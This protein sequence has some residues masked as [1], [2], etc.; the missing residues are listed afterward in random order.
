MDRYLMK[1]SAPFVQFS[2]V[3][4]TDDF[5]HLFDIEKTTKQSND[6]YCQLLLYRSFTITHSQ[7]PDFIAH[8]CNLVNDPNK[9]LNKFEKLL[10]LNEELFSGTRNQSRLVKF[11]TC[12]ETKR[13]KLADE[14]A[15]ADKSKPVKKY[16]NAESEDRHFSFKET[17]LAIENLPDNKEKIYF[18]TSEIYEYRTADIVMKNQ[19]LPDFDIE[20]EKLIGKIQTLAKLR[21]EIEETKHSS[22]T[23]T[24][25]NE[26]IMLNGPINILT[27]AFKQMMTSVKPNGKPYI[28]GKIKDI[29]VFL[30]QNFVDESGNTL[31]KD[32]LQTY[33]SP[34]RND[35]DP[36]SDMQ[37]NF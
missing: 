36:N 9:W 2:S 19:K 18:L 33:L 26:K 21:A 6:D 16:I 24:S 25:H 3:K 7:I 35:K 30:E 14:A 8:H 1:E 37:V 29:A 11:Y 31:S 32:T 27:N 34:G 12:I 23:A 17:R 5:N 20:C 22:N 15:K 4:V 13:N 10:T 28:Q